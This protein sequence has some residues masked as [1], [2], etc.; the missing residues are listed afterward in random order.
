MPLPLSLLPV[1]AVA[2]G[3]TTMGPL[4][5]T[6]IRHS[7]VFSG[8]LV[9]DVAVVVRVVRGAESVPPRPPMTLMRKWP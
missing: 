4:L 8:V 3:K 5:Q 7:S 2:P 1:V 6:R 9:A